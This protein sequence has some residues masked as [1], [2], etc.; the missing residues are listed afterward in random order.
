MDSLKIVSLCPSNTELLYYLHLLPY[1]V[2]VDN[3]SDWPITGLE[4]ATRL[5]PDL[6]IDIEKLVQLKPDL[7]LASLSVPGMETVVKN[8]Q[9]TSIPTLVLSPNTLADILLDM[10]RVA[11]TIRQ[12]IPLPHSVSEQI[13]QLQSRINRIQTMTQQMADKPTLYWEWWPNPMIS[14]AKDNWLTE[15]SA[16]AGA[17]NIFAEFEGSQFRDDG[18]LIIEANP[19]YMFIVWT[20]IQQQKVPLQKII[21]RSGFQQTNAFQQQRL[22]ILSEGLYCRPSPRLIDGL[23]QLIGL[24][25]PELI[26]VLHIG[27][28]ESYG[29]VRMWDGTWLNN[30]LP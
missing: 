6:H 8:V 4:Q 2:G 29:P 23:E 1:V 3:Y 5:G 28:P 11:E 27:N 26:S 10:Q 20:G 25:H 14:P 7:V 24:I 16:L 15:M 30:I 12:W 17:K 22:F 18:K 13:F 9:A 19:D 21:S